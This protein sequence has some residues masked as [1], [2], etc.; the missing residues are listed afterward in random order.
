[1]LLV[2]GELECP[3]TNPV[4]VSLQDVVEAVIVDV[5]VLG[6]VNYI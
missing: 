1:M 2:F 3:V 4:V 5:L 6:H